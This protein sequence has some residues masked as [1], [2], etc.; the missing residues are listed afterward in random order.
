MPEME[1]RTAIGKWE[2]ER[3]NQSARCL[4]TLFEFCRKKILPDDIRQALLDIV[5]CCIRHDHLL[6][7]ERYI[8]L[9]IGN[10]PWPI[11][12][13]MVGIH[14]RSAREKISANRVAHIMNDETTHQCLRSI[15]RLI[16]LYEPRYLTQSHN[17]E[18]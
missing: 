11:E 17:P 12:V 18:N 14:E 7:M 1:K 4:G 8:K 2:V 9:A 5:E 3:F 10:D 6:A 15:K 13:T 16:T